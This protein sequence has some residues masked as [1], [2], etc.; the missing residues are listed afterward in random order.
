M[1]CDFTYTE[2]SAVQACTQIFGAKINHSGF[3]N[4]FFKNCVKRRN[5]NLSVSYVAYNLLLQCISSNGRNLVRVGH[6]LSKVDLI[7][8]LRQLPVID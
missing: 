1:D 2:I 6:V 7:S 3:E 5:V 8:V 4:L